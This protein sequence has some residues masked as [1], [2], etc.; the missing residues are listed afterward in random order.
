[1]AKIKRQGLDGSYTAVL[2]P[3]DFAGNGDS[4]ED[5]VWGVA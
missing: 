5:A 1:M 4:P 2:N 3:L